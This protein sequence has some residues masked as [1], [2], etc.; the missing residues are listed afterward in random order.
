MRSTERK[1][2]LLL[3]S[4][5]LAAYFDVYACLFAC[6]IQYAPRVQ[7]DPN[8]ITSHLMVRHTTGQFA[9]A[10]EDRVSQ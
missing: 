6:N 1:G 3:M 5:D 9:G 4:P 2:K 7:T 8:L 10:E